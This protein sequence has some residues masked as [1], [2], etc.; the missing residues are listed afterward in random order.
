MVMSRILKVTSVHIIR[1]FL[2]SRRQT[3]IIVFHVFW[4]AWET[5]LFCRKIITTSHNRW[6]VTEI[7]IPRDYYTWEEIFVFQR[8]S[9]VSS[10]ENI[11]TLLTVLLRPVWLYRRMLEKIFVFQR[12][13]NRIPILIAKWH[14]I[15]SKISKKF[16]LLLGENLRP[17]THTE[18]LSVG[19][20]Y[21]FCLK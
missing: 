5:V 2:L 19:G 16:K 9:H 12:G 14:E 21:H 7:V 11:S 8:I 10:P 18:Q 3:K 17:H 15:A 13:R 6:S 1:Q 4:R 20:F